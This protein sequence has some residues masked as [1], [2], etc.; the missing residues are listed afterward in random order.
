MIFVAFV[1]L[2]TFRNIAL[3]CAVALVVRARIDVMELEPE[4]DGDIRERC[5]GL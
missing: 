3:F 1:I 4:K 2:F 5:F